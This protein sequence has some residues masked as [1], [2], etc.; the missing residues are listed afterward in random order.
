MAE[1][2]FYRPQPKDTVTFLV[3]SPSRNGFWPDSVEDPAPSST[4]DRV[5]LTVQGFSHSPN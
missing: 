2:V 1:T 4:P 3:V 5:N